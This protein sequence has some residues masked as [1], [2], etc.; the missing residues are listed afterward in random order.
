MDSQIDEIKRRIEI[1][2]LVSDYV[3]LRK[4]GRNYKGLCPF[5]TEKSPS[6][7]VNPE[8]GIFKC[9][10]CGKGG[11]IFKFLEE[12]EG[13]DFSESLKVLAKRA[14]VELK[15]YQPTAKAK[16]RERVL[17]A[18][19]LAAKFYQTVLLEHST[20]KVALEYLKKRGLKLSTIKEWGLGY[21]PNQWELVTKALGAKGYLAAEIVAT[22]LGVPSEKTNRPYDRFRGRIMFPIRD[23]TGRVIG[24]SGRI[25]GAGEP[26]YM[27]S[28]D[29]LVYQKSKILY[30]MDLAKNDI[31]KQNLAVL[32]EGNLDV[33]SS[34]Q[35]GV[36]N[37]VAPMGTALT[38]DQVSQLMR[39]AETAAL[40][41][42]T[43]LAGDAATRRGIE[44]ADDAGLNIRIV[45]LLGKDPDEM[46]QESV[47]GWRE[48]VGRATPIYDFYLESAFA[49]ADAS[50]PEGK[51]KIAREVL[52]VL[53][54]ISDPVLRGHYVKLAAGRLLLEEK[55]LEQALNRERVA[56]RPQTSAEKIDSRKSRQYLLEEEVVRLTLELRERATLLI[57]DD[58]TDEKIGKIY[59]ALIKAFPES[60]DVDASGLT[61][62]VKFDT[63]SFVETLPSEVIDLF[64]EIALKLRPEEDLD[65]HLE[66]KVLLQTARELRR[67]SLRR[68]LRK[69]GLMIK[70]AQASGEEQEL[71]KLNQ[72]FRKLSGQLANLEV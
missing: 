68:L 30:G 24:F 23:I 66:E 29:S 10:G 21:A 5:H 39:F 19:A 33:I 1:L 49:K 59:R 6:F 28:P 38:L 48:A 14:G 70:Q 16:E 34:H 13:Y 54:K 72:K 31:K 44:L 22:G 65:D 7:M 71:T 20:G 12:V 11:D 32:V 53:R 58:F 26:K 60:E 56:E 55:Y 46:I 25:L 45:H 51:R 52:P 62:K 63:P 18:Q 15:S 42:D 36:K 57:P 43:D 8:R 17:A 50:S 4:S 27:N 61:G 3:T 37:V 2:D 35:A 69:L 9:F 47:E 64:D 40:A 67:S 41:F